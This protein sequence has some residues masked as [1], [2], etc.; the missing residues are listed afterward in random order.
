M[1]GETA[2]LSP[3]LMA[4]LTELE[5]RMGFELRID[6]GYRDPTHNEDVGGVEGSEHTHDP[7]D[8]V[9][10]FCQRSV[11]RFQMVRELLALGVRRI[12]IGKTFVHV[13]V[14]TDHPQEVLW[15][16]YKRA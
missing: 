8:A 3:A 5:Q 16:Y 10:V 15:T 12:G 7:A 9:D 13:G 14:S 1:T 2:N 6:S 4:V 11:T